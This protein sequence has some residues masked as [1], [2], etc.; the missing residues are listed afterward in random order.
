MTLKRYVE[1]DGKSIH[2]RVSG[3]GPDVIVLHDSVKSSSALLP[4]MDLLSDKFR[5]FA[6]D[7]PGYGDSTSLLDGTSIENFSAVLIKAFEKVGIQ[8]PVLY[9]R[10]T[11]AKVSVELASKHGSFFHHI[12]LDGLSL[13]DSGVE[14]DF[15]TNYLPEFVWSHRIYTHGCASKE[16]Y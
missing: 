6:F 12:L 14:D 4:L 11:G 8:K 13:P 7:L 1:V 16:L 15:L 9:G 5:V 3:Q 10:H 2:Y